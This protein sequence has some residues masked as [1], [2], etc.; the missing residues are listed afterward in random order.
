MTLLSPAEMQYRLHKQR[1]LSGIC[2][3]IALLL[4]FTLWNSWY[5]SRIS[6]QENIKT[7]EATIKILE[8]EKA[9]LVKMQN[10]L[11]QGSPKLTQMENLI[12]NMSTL[13]L[14]TYFYAKSSPGIIDIKNIA[15]A[16]PTTL[17]AGYRSQVITLT[18][19]ART[20]DRLRAFLSYLESSTEKKRFKVQ[21]LQLDYKTWESLVQFDTTVTLEHYLP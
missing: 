10:E 8:A 16:P 14:F 15:I 1:I 3:S 21:Q 9:D 17:P 18:V 4:L 20:V 12:G 2:L 7:Q 19:S 13:E 5:F 6:L 11:S